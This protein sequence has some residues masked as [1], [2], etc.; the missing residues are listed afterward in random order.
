M[1]VYIE[2]VSLI[3][4]LGADDE[5]ILSNL[6]AGLSPGMA[7]PTVR[8]V[9]GIDVPFGHAAVTLPETDLA[10][11]RNQRLL[12]AAWDAKRAQFE[13]LMVDMPRDRIAVIMGTST[14]ASQEFSDWWRAQAKGIESPHFKGEWQEMGDPARDLAAY[15]GITGP[16]MTIATAC[17]SSA[18]ALI[19]GARLLES[20]LVDAVIAGGADTLAEMPLNG[21]HALGV[22]ASTLTRPLT[23]NRPGITIG[24]GAGIVWM[25]KSPKGKTSVTLSGWG[26]SSDGYHMSSP[27]PEGSGAEKAIQGALQKANLPPDA[28]QYVNLHG[29]GTEQNDAAEL[30]V[31]A[32]VFEGRVPMS[33]TKALTGHTLG[34]AGI[35][36]AG[37]LILMLMKAQGLTLPAQFGADD[38]LDPALMMAG[39]IREQTT[40]P[41]G[42]VMSN[43][44]AFGGNNTSLIFEPSQK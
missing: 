37:L 23:A 28:I 43:N 36:D 22:L 7:G 30:A 24:E 20:G 16:A 4:A 15:L 38:T 2:A 12:R 31:M 27:E 44:F 8:T 14:A 6:A 42:P 19:S 3:N 25:T 18:R 40:L 11:P 41:I 26:E 29:T 21:F 13:C 34:A 39:V 5:T 35:T 32:R 10:I 1:T 33:S 9:D 17:T